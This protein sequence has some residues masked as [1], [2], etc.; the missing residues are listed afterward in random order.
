MMKTLLHLWSKMPL[1]MH[2]L[3]SRI[4]RPKFQVAVASLVFDEQGRILL[5]KHTYRKF[6]WGIPAGG[7]EH[8]EQPADAVLREFFEETGMHIQIQKLLTVVS[9]K[10]GP[11]ITVV[12]VCRIVSGEFRES[13]EISE[14]QYFDLDALPQMLFAEKELIRQVASGAIS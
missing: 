10:E 5:F 7:L 12:Y 8:H 13:L 4:V 2:Y 11:Y 1:W 6:P 3:A 14:M 9:A